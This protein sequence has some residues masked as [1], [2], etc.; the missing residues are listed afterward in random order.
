MP[1]FLCR[2][3]S[4]K[5][6]DL[7]WAYTAL[8]RQ[9]FGRSSG[10]NAKCISRVVQHIVAISMLCAWHADVYLFSFLLIY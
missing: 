2:R 7:A 6:S 8:L 1:V 3:A 10:H 4:E 9:N 5:V